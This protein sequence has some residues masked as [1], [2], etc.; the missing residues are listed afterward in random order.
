[1]KADKNAN[2]YYT[3]SNM[4]N[5]KKGYKITRTL[6]KDGNDI[7]HFVHEERG[8]DAELSVPDIYAYFEEKFNNWDSNPELEKF[9]EEFNVSAH[10][11]DDEDDFD[12]ELEDEDEK[13]TKKTSKKSTKP[14]ADDDDDD[15]DDFDEELEDEDEDIPVKK[16]KT[17]KKQ[18]DHKPITKKSKTSFE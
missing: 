2:P 17:E 16:S 10:Q 1:M 5:T 13:D 12:E 4:A 14:V 15:D 7:F 3:F 11:D 6:D 9:L 8:I 18:V